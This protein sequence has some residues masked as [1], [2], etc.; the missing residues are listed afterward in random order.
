MTP[1]PFWEL[2][3]FADNEGYIGP[4]V[5][6]KLATDFANWADRAKEFAKDPEVGEW[7]L[8]S[9]NKW[10]QAFE[11]AADGGVVDFH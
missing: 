5:A 6:A 3:Q 4:T 8:V 11:L 7:W 9:Y 1:G 10:R 2:I